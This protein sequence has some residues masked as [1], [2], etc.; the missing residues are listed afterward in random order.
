MSWY[1]FPDC[2]PTVRRKEVVICHIMHLVVSPNTQGHETCI[3]RDRLNI[4]V[5][6]SSTCRE[7][8]PT[9]VKA[10]KRRVQ[11]DKSACAR[12]ANVDDEAETVGQI[13][14]SGCELIKM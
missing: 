9:S 5:S 8:F 14:E 1:P 7:S 2:S 3:L 6:S 11:F 4:C 13:R 10:G 12:I